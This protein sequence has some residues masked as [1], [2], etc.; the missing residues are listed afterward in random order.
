[1]ILKNPLLHALRDCPTVSRT[2]VALIQPS[3]IPKFFTMNIHEWI[4]FNLDYEIGIKATKGWKEIFL[5]ACWKIWY[6][7]NKE[8]A[9]LPFKFSESA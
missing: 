8:L 9:E 2:W 7:R 4:D 1:M 6:W 5:I 3:S